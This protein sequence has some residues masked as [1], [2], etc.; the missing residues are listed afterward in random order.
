MVSL[1]TYQMNTSSICLVEKFFVIFLIFE[2]WLLDILMDDQ[3]LAR[4]G[5]RDVSCS[6]L[7]LAMLL[8]I[9]VEVEEPI[10]IASLCCCH[11]AYLTDRSVSSCIAGGCSNCGL[12]MRKMTRP[13]TRCLY[14][15]IRLP[16]GRLHEQF[17]CLVLWCSSIRIRRPFQEMQGAIESPLMA[18]RFHGVAQS[19]SSSRA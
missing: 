10:L 5:I 11:V 2:R 3:P 15:Y 6:L 1:T 4:R 13:T 19:T 16:D 17:K 14:L 12:V 18:A 7:K 8:Y 9:C